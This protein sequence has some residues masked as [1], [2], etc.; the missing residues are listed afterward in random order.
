MPPSSGDA[1]PRMMVLGLVIQQPDTAA[2]VARRLAEQFSSARFPRSSAHK[3]LPNLAHRGYL[4]LV[5]KGAEPSLDR[6]EAT[7]EG[8]EHLRGWL[9]GSTLPPT[10]RDA[11]Q[12]KLEFLGLEDL[13]ALVQTVREEEKAYSYA[14]DIAHARVLQEQRSRRRSG[15]T[16]MDWH[17]RLR[18]IQ[19]KD[20]ATLWSMMSQRLERLLGELQELLEE[21]SATP[22]VD[23]D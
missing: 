15:A 13:V 12:G 16:K 5:E 9:R 23:D 17:I 11:L 8:I 4:R 14:C 20:E 6:Y 22:M 18:G 7:Q 10:L 2:G 21:V 3:N 1:T 19:S